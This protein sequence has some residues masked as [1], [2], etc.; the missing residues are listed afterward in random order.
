[1]NGRRFLISLL[2]LGIFPYSTTST[3]RNQIP[4]KPL[5][6]HDAMGVH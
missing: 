1:M 3:Y 4:K 5:P 2:S 6:E